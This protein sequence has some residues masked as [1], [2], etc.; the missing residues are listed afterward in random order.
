MNVTRAAAH[1]QLTIRTMEMRDLPR[2]VHIEQ[3]TGVPHWS[4]QR[5]KAAMQTGD[6]INLVATVRN[7]VVG[8]AI[9]RL[10][11]E[12]DLCGGDLEAC[13]GKQAPPKGP[14]SPPV[15]LRLLHVAVAA[16]WRRHGIGAALVSQFEQFLRLPQ[17]CIRAAVPETN[18]P[19]Q[20]LLRS[21]GYRAKR[22]LRDFYCSEDAYLM[23]WQ[24][25]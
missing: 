24:R 22:V 6:R 17:D 2:L 13:T 3:Q 15:Y 14:A 23:E 19:I 25:D 16:D 12:N 21:T 7:T 9:A 1:R 18:L 10:I 4:L 11:T 5:F 20:L 8:F